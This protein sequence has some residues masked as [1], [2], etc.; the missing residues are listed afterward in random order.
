[1]WKFHTLHLPKPSAKPSAIPRYVGDLDTISGS[2]WAAKINLLV[3]EEMCFGERPANTDF[4]I[5]PSGHGA[6]GEPDCSV[7]ICIA[8]KNWNMAHVI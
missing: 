1:M 6:E 4:D 3:W 2:I 8:Q 7:F 5:H